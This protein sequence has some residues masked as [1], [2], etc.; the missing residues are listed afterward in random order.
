MV[1]W[2]LFSGLLVLVCA[3]SGPAES[4]EYVE[5]FRDDFNDHQVD[6]SKWNVITAPSHVNQE[7]QHYAWDDVWEEHGHLFLRSQRRPYGDRQYTSGRVD[8]QYKFQFLY[9]EVE[10][11]AQ[12]PK[13]EESWKASWLTQLPTTMT[14]HR[15]CLPLQ[16]LFLF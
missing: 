13:G 2:H 3:F 12:L 8:T 5:V 6:S 10:W 7:L 1:S 14:H 11:R 16:L 9:G 4:L 15:C